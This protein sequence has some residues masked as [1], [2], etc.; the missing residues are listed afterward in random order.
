MHINQNVDLILGES[1][2]IFFSHSLPF[3]FCLSLFD[4][5]A[6]HFIVFLSYEVL[7]GFLSIKGTNLICK[8]SR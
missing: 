4:S 6:V 7:A 8:T 2:S 5:F 1:I 3:L